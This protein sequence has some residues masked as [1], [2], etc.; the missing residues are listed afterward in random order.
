ME[1][2]SRVFGQHFL[3]EFIGCDAKTISHVDQ[4]QPIL[5][6]SARISEATI[7]EHFFKQYEPIGVTGIILISE[8]HFSVH[9]WPEDQYVAFD[10][11]TCG[12]M[13]P[14]K[15]IDYLAQKFAAKDVR[16]QVLTRG[17]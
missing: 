15:A 9:T 5:L 1:N 12:P 6:E 8:S 3:V 13:Y 10:I 14:E 4:V 16:K 11:L 17:I 2:P 7:V